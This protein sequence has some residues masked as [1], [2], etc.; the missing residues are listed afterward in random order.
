VVPNDFEHDPG[1]S[2]TRVT[3]ASERGSE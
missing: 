2:R 1:I 3:W